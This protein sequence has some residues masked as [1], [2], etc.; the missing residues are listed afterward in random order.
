MT[1][2]DEQKSSATVALT[3]P[4]AQRIAQRFP[5]T[6]RPVSTGR[7]SRKQGAPTINGYGIGTSSPSFC[8]P[9]DLDDEYRG[10]RLRP[11]WELASRTGN[12]VLRR[13]CLQYEAEVE[14][15]AIV[16]GLTG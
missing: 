8:A 14:G 1:Q 10:R 2:L 3:A 11:L 9:V 15:V 7:R 12:S 16:G 13:L 4:V 6:K 5:K